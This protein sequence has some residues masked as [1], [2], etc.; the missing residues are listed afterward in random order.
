MNLYKTFEFFEN[1]KRYFVSEET[2]NEINNKICMHELIKTGGKTLYALYNDPTSQELRDNELRRPA[3]A[4]EDNN[5]PG[6]RWYW[7]QYEHN[8]KHYGCHLIAD[9]VC[10]RKCVLYY[11]WDKD[12]KK[13]VLDDFVNKYNGEIDPRW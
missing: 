2:A 13:W 9:G 4:I 3:M 12:S 6:V 1:G 10:V 8:P 11:N 5:V 7:R